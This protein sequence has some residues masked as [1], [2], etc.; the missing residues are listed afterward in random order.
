MCGWC[1][2]IL[3]ADIKQLNIFSDDEVE[4]VV[5]DVYN[6]TINL[7]NLDVHTYQKTAKQLTDGVFTGFGK[8]MDNILI[9]TPDY[10]MLSD[11]RENVYVFSGAKNYQQVRAMS[12]LLT[13]DGAITGF[14]DYKKKATNVF[15]EYN[16]NYLTAEYNSA[17][18]QSRSASQWMEIEADKELYN[19]LQYVTANDGRVRPEHALLNNIVRPIDDKFWST[20]M[21]P[22]GWN[23]R[24]DVLQVNEVE[25]TLRGDIPKMTDKQ[26]PEIFR[27]NAGKERIVF[28]ENHPYFNI[29]DR[30]IA[31]AKTN[32]GLPIP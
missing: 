30:D 32:F 19:Q 13:T 31:F 28:S 14:N 21:P 7:R 25:N 16:K 23:C 10:K 24:C 9:N 4:R 2:D 5:Y 3:N 22:N 18:A 27:M 26:V 15:N 8:N 6:G 29:A 17:I 11:L 20:Y 12:E 1:N